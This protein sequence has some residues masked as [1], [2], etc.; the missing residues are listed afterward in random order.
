MESWL[1]PLQ[2]VPKPYPA[3]HPMA[4]LLRARS[5]T[6]H[7]RHERAQWLLTAELLDRLLEDWR[8]LVPLNR[9]LGS[10]PEA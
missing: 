8:A 3:D 6:L 7:R 9:W 5:L 2:R 4:E 10:L 1:D